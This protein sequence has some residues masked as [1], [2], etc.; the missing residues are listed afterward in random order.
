LIFIVWSKDISQAQEL[1]RHTLKARNKD[2]P[3]SC[4]RFDPVLHITD[5]DSRE[6]EYPLSGDPLFFENKLYEFDFQFQANRFITVPVIKHRLT[7][8]EDAFHYSGNSLR[9][10]INF[11]NDVGWFKLI[12]SYQLNGKE[13][14]QAISFKV[15]PTKMDIETD[16]SDIQQ[17][18]DTQYPL[19]RFSFA[20]K[21]EQELA[22]SRKPHERFP[23]LWLS[24]FESL[25]LELEKGVKQ[26]LQC[27]HSAHFFDFH[28]GSVF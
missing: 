4:L 10:S 8:I 2:L 25:R 14:S 20:Q 13:H 26:V 3:A 1:L 6:N 5:L 24:Q 28:H 23:L 18:I 21:T 9:G 11:G 7:S 16:L 22:R 19:L 27:N 12:L 15:L 17:V